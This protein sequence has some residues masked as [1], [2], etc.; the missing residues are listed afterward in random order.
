LGDNILASLYNDNSI[1]A[2]KL[3]FFHLVV[4]YLS[5]MPMDTYDRI[6]SS[7]YITPLLNTSNQDSKI[8]FCIISTHRHRLT[9]PSIPKLSADLTSLEQRH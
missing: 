7:P 5:M 1:L 9:H 6:V 3:G 4:S 8:S 2:L